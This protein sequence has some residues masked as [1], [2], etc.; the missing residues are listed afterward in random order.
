M[1]RRRCERCRVSTAHRR[2]HICHHHYL[3]S[4]CAPYR[5]AQCHK[6]KKYV[7]STC[8]DQCSQCDPWGKWTCAFCKDFTKMN[9][10][11]KWCPVHPCDRC[12]KRCICREKR[13]L[14]EDHKESACRAAD[15]LPRTQIFTLILGCQQKKAPNKSAGPKI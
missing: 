12:V 1:P 6:C 4:I 14:C 11:T 3:C 10:V 9:C 13:P 7:C 15:C 8:R 5:L 2:C